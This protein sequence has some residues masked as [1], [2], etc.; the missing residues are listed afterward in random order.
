M[1]DMLLL[2][3]CGLR[4]IYQSP[5]SWWYSNLIHEKKTLTYI[6]LEM[7]HSPKLETIVSIGRSMHIM[8]YEIKMRK[9]IFGT[10]HDCY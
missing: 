4:F 10:E 7:T 2:Y 5:H 8:N 6:H 1:A 3:I 9:L